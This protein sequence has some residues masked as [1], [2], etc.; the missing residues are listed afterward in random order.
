[1]P[2]TL[3]QQRAVAN[4]LKARAQPP[5]CPICGAANMTVQE[6]VTLLPTDE[7]D[8]STVP[9]INVVC[10]YCGHVLHFSPSALGL[11]LQ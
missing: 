11:S 4:H 7:N 2:L 3:E 6:E 8:S 10:K 1:M 9:R 5:Q